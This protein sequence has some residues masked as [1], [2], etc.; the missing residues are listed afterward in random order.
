VSANA[1]YYA[2]KALSPREAFTRLRPKAPA[3]PWPFPVPQ[4]NRILFGVTL[5]AEDWLTEQERIFQ[6]WVMGDW[7]HPWYSHLGTRS[8]R[9][10]R[11]AFYAL[12]LRLFVLY[13]GLVYTLWSGGLFL[14]CQNHEYGHAAYSMDDGNYATLFFGL[15]GLH[16]LHVMAGLALLAWGLAR[17]FR[18]AF[19]ADSVPHVGATAGIWYWHFVDVVWILLFGVVYLWGN[20]S[21]SPTPLPDFSD[22]TTLLRQN[23]L[24]TRRA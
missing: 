1:H 14:G 9:Q 8:L 21:G 5:T 13:G 3:S 11:L 2:L 24:P 16:G 18:H 6:T 7:F 15:T 10:I 23:L 22:P 19:L 12:R 4:P 17:F 20:S